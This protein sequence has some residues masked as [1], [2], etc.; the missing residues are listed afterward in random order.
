MRRGR[1]VRACGPRRSALLRAVGARIGGAVLVLWAV[2]TVTFL[3]VRLIPGDPAQAILG[4]PGSQAP[5]EAVAAVR[6]EYGLDQPLLVQYLAQLGRLA[7]GDLGRSYALREDVVAVLAR[8]LPGT[9]LLAVLALAVAWILALASPSS[10]RARA[11]SPRRSARAS[12]SWRP[13]C[14]TSGSAWC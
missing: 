9:L 2:A 3:A 7:Q 12:R 10:P 11:G 8:Q 4:G 6:A 13:R 5:P 14:R 1:A